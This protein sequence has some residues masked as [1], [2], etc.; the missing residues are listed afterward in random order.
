MCGI[1][2]V[3]GSGPVAGSI[4]DALKCLEYRGYDSAGIAALEN[5]KLTWRRA[6]GVSYRRHHGQRC[7]PAP[8]SGE[9]GDSG[10][11]EKMTTPLPAAEIGRRRIHSNQPGMQV[12]HAS[13]NEPSRLKTSRNLVECASDARWCDR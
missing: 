9:I 6:E 11:G 7:R 4:V 13:T 3:L 12:G 10:V 2:G 8:Q 5:G 1:V